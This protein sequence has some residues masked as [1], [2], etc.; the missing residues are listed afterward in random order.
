M[1]AWHW[2]HHT[3]TAAT[4][5][6][7]FAPPV[8][9]RKAKLTSLVYTPG[10]TAHDLVLMRC[11]DET[12][13]TA[14]SA[15]TDTTLDVGKV[16]FADQTL[17]SGD[18][19]LIE[20]ADGTFEINTVSSVASLVITLNAGVAKA[21]NAGD[22]VWMF[23]HPTNE[24]AYHV[25]LK[26]IASTRIEFQSPSAGLVEGGIGPNIGIISDYERDGLGDPLLF[27]SANGTVAGILNWAS[28]V[29]VTGP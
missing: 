21:V 23:G 4:A 2:D 10:T 11:I 9:G 22:R 12:E 5:I 1:C 7:E 29:Y 26:S 8:S 25:T 3:E 14:A 18:Y 19:L 13:T 28:G 27:Y 16:T 17:A 20:H 24:A 15:A 6:V